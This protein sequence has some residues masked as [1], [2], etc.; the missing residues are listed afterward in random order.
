M[1][2]AF[3]KIRKKLEHEKYTEKELN[4]YD[5]NMKMKNKM[6]NVGIDTALSIVSEVEAEYGKDIN[7]RGN[8]W[9]PCSER[10]PNHKHN[11]LLCLESGYVGEGYYSANGFKDV[12]SYPYDNVIAWQPLPLPYQ[13]RKGV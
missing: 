1:K 6:I 13:P 7:V 4:T 2:E 8:G 9:I 3:E 10:L 5:S 12:N 11:L